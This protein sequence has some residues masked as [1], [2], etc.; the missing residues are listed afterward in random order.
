MKVFVYTI[1]DARTA[2]R[3]ASLGVDGI[4]TNRVTTIRKALAN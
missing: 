2:R 3:L 1:N 4:I